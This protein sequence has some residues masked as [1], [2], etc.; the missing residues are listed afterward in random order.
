M[1]VT[2]PGDFGPDAAAF[3]VEISLGDLVGTLA[4]QDLGHCLSRLSLVRSRD[5]QV[6]GG[7]RPPVR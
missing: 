6:S 5:L 3:T 1:H 7:H 4:D 2:A